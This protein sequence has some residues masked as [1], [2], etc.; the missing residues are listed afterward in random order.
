MALFALAFLYSFRQFIRLMTI[1]P[2]TR[3]QLVP[4]QSSSV[5]GN[6]TILL[7][8]EIGNYYELNEVGGFIWALLQERKEVSVQEIQDELLDEFDV[9]PVVCQAELTQF[10]ES[11]LHEKLIE[12][13]E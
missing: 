11:L 10:L 7:N 4:N 9:D 13:T 1:T 5:L 12:L 3:I 2:A 8:Y 6:E